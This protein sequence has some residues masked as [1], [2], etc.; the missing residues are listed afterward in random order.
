MHNNQKISHPKN[1]FCHRHFLE[2]NSRSF[3]LPKF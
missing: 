2:R 1:G 3:I